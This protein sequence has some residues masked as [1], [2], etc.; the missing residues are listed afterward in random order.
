MRSETRV[1]SFLWA[2]NG[3]CLQRFSATYL[4]NRLEQ[5]IRSLKAAQS[6]KI[7]SES[8]ATSDGHCLHQDY[9]SQYGAVS[10]L[11]GSDN[12]GGASRCV[13][14]YSG[15]GPGQIMLKTRGWLRVLA[16]RCCAPSESPATAR[17][18]CLA[19]APQPKRPSVAAQ[20]VRQQALGVLIQ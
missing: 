8:F 13:T 9:A 16:S 19:A 14:S 5:I 4:H 1:F 15:V 10:W 7:G 3:L 11:I 18:R 17:Q 6:F 20:T 12:G 2:V